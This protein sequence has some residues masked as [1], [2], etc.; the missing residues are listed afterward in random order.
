M[1]YPLLTAGNQ[2]VRKFVGMKAYNA[3]YGDS[4]AFIRSTFCEEGGK[5]PGLFEEDLAGEV[6]T[7]LSLE[8][9]EDTQ[10]GQTAGFS[11]GSSTR[12]DTLTGLTLHLKGWH[13]VYCEPKAAALDS[14]ICS[15][16]Q[17]AIQRSFLQGLGSLE[18][19]FSKHCPLW[20]GWG[21]RKL[22]LLQRLHYFNIVVYPFYSIPLF[23]YCTLPA[24]SLI[25]QK[26]PFSQVI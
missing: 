2:A 22:R 10:W 8:F 25:V 18:I 14:L 6:I 13:S 1:T 24:S 12:S 16:V 3:H 4:T 15:S 17:N 23:L 21:E 19:L 9:E 7:V 26:L 11:Y 20:Y 5:V